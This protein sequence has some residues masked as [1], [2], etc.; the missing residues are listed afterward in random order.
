M[1]D[2][3]HYLNRGGWLIFQNSEYLYF[4]VDAPE[5]CKHLWFDASGTASCSV[6]DCKPEMCAGYPEG[7]TEY[8]NA[9]AGRCGF[10]FEETPWAGI[11]KGGGNNV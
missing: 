7:P 5:P 4:I 1:S 11:D 9:I 10:R 8:F 2:V 3:E 6:H